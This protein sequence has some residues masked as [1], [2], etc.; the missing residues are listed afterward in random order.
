MTTTTQKKKLS[1]AAWFL[2][3]LLIGTV[4]TV[5]VLAAIGYISLQFLADILVGYSTFGSYG[6]VESVITV[7][8]PFV[9]GILFFWIVKTYFIGD[10]TKGAIAT[11][12]GYSPT[13]VY[14][15]QH[16]QD[17]ETVIS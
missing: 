9:T 6:W 4:I 7:T 11:G 8:I 17:T 13:P 5:I 15:S 3:F 16:Q 10:K 12:G 14:P 2:I 1:K